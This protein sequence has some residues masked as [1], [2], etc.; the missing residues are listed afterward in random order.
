MY[1][2]GPNDYAFNNDVSTCLLVYKKIYFTDTFIYLRK[3]QTQFCHQFFRLTSCKSNHLVGIVYSFVRRETEVESFA[4][5]FEAVRM[6]CK[7]TR[8]S[9][10]YRNQILYFLTRY[11]YVSKTLRILPY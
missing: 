11:I 3:P 1:V 6:H 10:S 4:T 5:R 7:P 2:Y 9:R 8:E